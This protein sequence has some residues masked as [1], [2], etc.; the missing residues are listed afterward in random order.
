MGDEEDSF[1]GREGTDVAH[2][3]LEPN[4]T[5]D[6]GLPVLHE[7]TDILD[8]DARTG[9]LP[10]SG[11]RWLAS[12]AGLTG[13][14]LS[15]VRSTVLALS[16]RGHVKPPRGPPRGKRERERPTVFLRNLQR[17]QAR[18]LRIS[19]ACFRCSGKSGPRR[20]PTRFSLSVL[21]AWE[22]R[23]MTVLEA[24]L[25][26]A[27]RVGRRERGEPRPW[28]DGDGP[29]DADDADDEGS[30]GTGTTM[31]ADGPDR[32]TVVAR[33]FMAVGSGA[34]GSDRCCS[35]RSRGEV[36]AYDVSGGEEDDDVGAGT[37]VTD[38]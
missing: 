4:V 12:G 17:K 24:L 21:V 32:A 5:F 8:V 25:V 9:H 28:E 16:P 6:V 15:N 23:R 18:N 27:L 30:M 20:R 22:A 11:V 29:A 34:G 38:E 3:E 37:I 26:G 7:Q 2:R 13:I 35:C 36:V 33:R 19:L 14:A 10:Q 31:A 1:G